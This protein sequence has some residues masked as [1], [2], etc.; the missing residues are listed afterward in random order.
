MKDQLYTPEE[1]AET[2]KISK[3]TVYEKIKRGELDAHRI[4]R[5][6]RISDLHLAT[7]L[8]RTCEKENVFTADI[9]HE[10]DQTYAAI[11]ATR[12]CVDTDLVGQA[13]IMIG[14]E[15]VILSKG[16]FSSSARN[17]LK[18]TVDEIVEEG[19][20]VKIRLDVGISL[21]ALIT[22]KSFLEMDIEKGDELYAIFKTMSVRVFK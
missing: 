13:R 18:G 11:G 15:D 17:V 14:P 1:I 4:G 16:V 8:A 7:Y 5:H 2:L 12:I 19:S 10:N 20:K 6:L 9:L 22:K 3:Y 21:W